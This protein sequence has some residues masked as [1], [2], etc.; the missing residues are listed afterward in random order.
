MRKLWARLHRYLGLTAALFLL[1]ASLT[2]CIIAYQQELDAWL[3][4]ELFYSSAQGAALTDAQLLSALQRELPEYR[5]VSLPLQRV[6][7]RA[8]KITLR[9]TQADM[10]AAYDEV[11]VDPVDG[12]VLG[13]RIWGACGLERKQLIPCVYVLHYSLQL[14]GE[15][16]LWVMGI[17]AVIVLLETL[18]GFYLSLP[19]TA[20]ALVRREAGAS[21]QSWRTAWRIKPGARGKRL[22]FDLHRAGGLWLSGFLLILSVSAISLNLRDALFEPLVGLFSDF[23]P[24]PFDARD[25][26]AEAEPVEAAVSF[27]MVLDRAQIEA[28]ARHWTKQRSSVFYNAQYGIFGVGYGDADGLGADYLY[29]DGQTAAYLD[30]Y[31]PGQGTAADIFDAWQLPLHSG[32][33][34]GLPGR[35]AV[36]VL[37]LA[38]AVLVVTGFRIWW[39]K[40]GR[41]ATRRS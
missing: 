31:L 30:D 21:R 38:I 16:G 6:A 11:F 12:K 33:I 41:S 27:V 9:P 39:H 7:G 19:Q 10:P 23:T 14:P 13:G 34:A 32:R 36:S 15:I 3:N 22:N 28:D 8:A 35:V 17:V 24:S 40:S 29:Y 2:G 37:G 4:P 5:V 26:R 18:I 20:L 1:Q 25:D